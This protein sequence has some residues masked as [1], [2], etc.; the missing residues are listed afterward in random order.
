MGSQ[1]ALATT[2]VLKHHRAAHLRLLG[3]VIY[4]WFIFSSGDA[5]SASPITPSGLNTQVS[6]PVELPNGSVQHNIT[7]GTRP[8]GGPNL[9][10]SFGDFSVPKSTIANFQNGVS[11]DINGTP[12][13]AG[14]PTANILA[15]VTNPNP[16]V[17][18]G[19]IQ[20]TNFDNAN[21]FLIN[22]AGIVFGP[23]A[24]LNVGGAVTFTTADYV[25]LSD[26]T[27]DAYFYTKA[28]NDGITASGRN[29]ILSSAPLVDFGFVTPA[30]FGFL[31]TTSA[32]IAIQS[33]TL[34]TPNG[35]SMS[36]V[37]G[38]QGF[39]FIN[40]DTNT[41]IS[42]P[43][44]I[45]MTGGK[46]SVPGG[47]IRIAS[48]SS[49]GE[50]AH[51]T[52]TT[53][54]NIN[55]QSV[56]TRG[57][58]EMSVGAV[59]TVEGGVGGTIKIIGGRL[60]MNNANLVADA[61]RAGSDDSPALSLDI[62]GDI[63][64]RGSSEVVSRTSSADRTGKL[65][66]NSHNLLLSEGSRI[67]T[68]TSGSSQAGD[69]AIIVADTISLTSTDIFENPSK[70][71]SEA[72]ANGASGSIT[73]KSATLNIRDRGTIRTE[74]AFDGP[75]G[76]IE[77][78]VNNLE[79]TTGGKIKSTGSE[80]ASS[81]NITVTATDTIQLLGQFDNDN[82]SGI[83]SRNEGSGGT[84]TILLNTNNLIMSD[85]ARVLNS[86]FLGLSHSDLVQLKVHATNLINLASESEIRITNFS[87]NAGSLE[88][89]ARTLTLNSSA[90][91]TTE[92]RAEGNAGAI[93]IATNDLRLT[94]GGQINSVSESGV[95]NGG[96]IYI[97]ATGNVLLSG[98]A[99][100]SPAPPQFSGIFSKTNDAF[101]IPSAT[102]GAGNI[103]LDVKTGAVTVQDGARI[104]SSS[105]GYALGQAGDISIKA[106]TLSVH[107]GILSSLTEF[108]GDA[109]AMTI[110]TDSLSVTNGGQIRSSA[111][112]R[113]APFF[114]GETI[115]TPTG[116]AGNITISGT[117]GPAQSVT[118][119]GSNSGVFTSTEGTG[120]GG[121]ITIT[122]D[123]TQLT[124]HAA[125]SAKT[126]GPGNAGDIRIK[127][128]NVTVSGGATITAASTGTGNAGTV[129]IQ[130]LHS[131]ANSFLLDGTGSNILTST[132]KTGA[133][134]NIVIAAKDVWLRNGGK[135]S[136]ETTGSSTSAT[137]GTITIQGDHVRIESGA[138]VTSAT[139]RVARGGSIA[140]TATESVS[141]KDG[142]VISAN[143]TGS[144]DAGSIAIHAGQRFDMQNGSVT[145][146]ASHAS[147]GNIE[148][149]ATDLVRVI[150]GQISTSV[151]G[152]SGNGG[153]ISIDPNTVILQNSQIV[154][155]AVA[156][157]GGNISITTPL[158]L[159]D[160]SSLVDASSLFGLN[161][162][163]TI[164]SPT[165]N[166]SGTIGQLSSKPT[167]IH[168]LVQNRCTALADGQQSTF[169]L[170]GRETF[171]TTPGGWI[172]SPFMVTNGYE[173]ASGPFTSVGTETPGLNEAPL[174]PVNIG[175]TGLL[176]LRSFTPPGF[177]V[178]SLAQAESTGCQL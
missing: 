155:K 98:R 81:G 39:D 100:T 138:L 156:G 104:D 23:H 43:G 132:T 117:A 94:N 170:S 48:L 175:S 68:E 8:G 88:L 149:N 127:S 71:E 3:F 91:I 9:F 61:T 22:P 53:H 146:S 105:T 163:V 5:F 134:G 57:P 14:L 154:A 10:H 90:Q 113:T 141:I 4:T 122:S 115:P 40:P 145:T 172:T 84:G 79:A 13:A 140:V 177:F 25:R 82:R 74:T 30:A 133:G 131:P 42:V 123:A 77:I 47:H 92:T 78:T 150:N 152:G 162:T 101:N 32:G 106:G 35:T 72:L 160:Q 103:H 121:N 166:L 124:N 50:I 128:N 66:I 136:A 27:Y 69:I 75:A 109:G 96:Q 51:Q 60:T 24:S 46:L 176:S 28:G 116:R 125:I 161:G 29:S 55:G 107:G 165:S 58:I 147:G 34:S 17:I 70:I 158:F 110:E 26:G 80:A 1:I 59:A 99:T 171:P 54:A 139:T 102:G 83:E 49:P 157:A 126:S 112:T 178:Q 33:S 148:I 44:G 15:R 164:Q 52:L 7:G 168:L 18:F 31:T 120:T 135:I 174:Q 11:F 76:N 89:S 108:A 85:R 36:F 64:L 56:T 6:D 143:S 173:A 114:E 12:L 45:T 62:L 87:G 19:T 21:L 129:T 86:A 2:A 73:I 118:I 137:G 167:P 38:S 151:L 37:G 130:G 16:S 142:A 41:Q 93:A 95:G 111:T 169:I 67:R 20:T 153:N 63:A 65:Q 97:V 119:S 144:G 159:A